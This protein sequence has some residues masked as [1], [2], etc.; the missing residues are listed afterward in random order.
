M[1]NKKELIEIKNII[2]KYIDNNIKNIEDIYE[3]N[4]LLNN[5]PLVKNLKTK[6]LELSNENNKL[7]K[8]IKDFK[9]KKNINL[10]IKEKKIDKCFENLYKNSISIEDDE[11]SDEENDDEEDSGDSDDENDKEDIKNYKENKKENTDSDYY[12]H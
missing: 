1:E 3:T 12:Y 6:I 4:I 7:K 5:L 2:D 8:E 10:V 9:I 11:D